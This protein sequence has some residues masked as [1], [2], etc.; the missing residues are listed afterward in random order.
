MTQPGIRALAGGSTEAAAGDGAEGIDG[1]DAG[2]LWMRILPPA[3]MFAIALWR[4]T[5][6]SYWRDEAATMTAV[7]RPFPGLL[8]MMGHVDA[9]HGVYYMIIWVV[10]RAGGSGEL[11]T[12]LPSAVAMTCAAAAV[13]ALGRRLVSPRA[14]LAAGVLFAALPQISLY[15]QDA[16]EYAGVTALAAAGDAVLFLGNDAKYLPAAYPGGFAELDDIDRAK[17]PGQAGNLVGARLP[18]RVTRARLGHVRRLWLVR[19]G[20]WP[21]PRILDGLG[22]RLVR[23]WRVSAIWLLLYARS[24]QVG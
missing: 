23:H 6:P 19:V 20:S 10:V 9:V 2:P 24:G 15:A 5:G 22:F 12:R 16:R 14:G 3:A 11:V 21:H 17:T 7:A 8:R 13:A 1:L 18:A 4:I